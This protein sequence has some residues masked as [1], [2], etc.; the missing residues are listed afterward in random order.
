MSIYPPFALTVEEQSSFHDDLEDLLSSI[1]TILS[2]PGP[3]SVY[4]W[5]EALRLV[6]DAFAFVTDMHDLSSPT[7]DADTRLATLFLYKGDCFRGLGRLREARD[8]YLAAC[9]VECQGS[10]DQASQFA[11]G[12]RLEDLDEWCGDDLRA[13]RLGGL[14]NALHTGLTNPDLSVLGYETELW[15]P[16]PPLVI[17]TAERWARRVE[18]RI[19]GTFFALKEVAG[20]SVAVKIQGLR[21]RKRENIAKV[22]TVEC[23]S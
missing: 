8:A 6:R 5:S 15:D 17:R 11:A 2:R 18:N 14:W 7:A 22:K 20:G 16:E 9:Q 10:E 3:L 4:D 13:K 12:D 1:Q 21:S 19:P 23:A